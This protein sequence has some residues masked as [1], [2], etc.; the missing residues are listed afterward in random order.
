MARP[1]KNKE[2]AYDFSDVESIEPLCPFTGE[3]LT[4]VRHDQ[5]GM[6]RAQGPFY[7]TRMFHFKRELIYWLLHREGEAPG[8]DPSI[9]VSVSEEPPRSSPVADTLEK[10]RRIQDRVDEYVE[11][12]QGVLGLKK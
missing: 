8:F 5:T 2:P 9:K 11:V 4:L 6:W 10:E 12:H 1:K 7:V 3:K